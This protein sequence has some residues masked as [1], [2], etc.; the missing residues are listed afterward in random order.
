MAINPN[1]PRNIRKKRRFY[2][3]KGFWLTLFLGTLILGAATAG[4]GYVVAERYTRE[5]RQRAATYDLDSINVLEV[6]SI[7]LDRNDK[8]IGRIFVQNRSIIPISE[9]PKILIDALCAGE[10]SRFFTHKGVDYIGILRAAKLN[11]QGSRQGASTITQQLARNAY[12]LKDEAELRKES[13]VQRK[14]VE[15]FLAM[16]IEHHF[17]KQQILEFYLNRIYF[18]SGFHGIRSAALGYFGKEPKDLSVGECASLV[19]LIKN[20]TGRSPINAPEVNR[21]GRNYVLGRMVE[22]KSLTAKEAERCKALPLK[23]N[24]QPLRRGTSHLYERIAEAVAQALGDDAL[25]AGGFKI[26][27]TILKEAQDAAEQSLLESLAR[28]EVQPGYAHPKYAD[29]RKGSSEPPEYLQGAVLMVDHESG[30]VLA[31]VGGRDY[32]QAPYDFIES[33]KRPLGTAFFPFLYAAGLSG[34]QTPATLVED[35]AMDNRAVMVGGREGI[36]GEWGM[37]TAAPPYYGK[38]TARRAFES[39]KI[40]AT[41]RFGSLVGLQRIAQTGVAFGLPMEHAELLQR[42]C[43]GWEEASMKQA[44]SAIAAFGRGGKTG[45][46]KLVY[47]DRVEDAQGIVKYRHEYAAVVSP[48]AVD[49]ATAWQIHSM[50]VGSCVRGSAAG[51]FDAL[52]EK[53][54]PGAGKGGSTYDFSDTWFL[55]YNKRVT[56]GVWTG[57][58][59]AGGGPIYAGAFSRD[60]ALP[61]WQ[62]AMNAAAPAFGGGE[63]A[64]P[65][66]L[67]EVPVCS[68]SG[69]R[70]TQFCQEMAED[71]ATGKL[72][73]RST[74]VIESFRRGTES[75]A[76]CSV[77]SGTSN[78]GLTALV[79]QP[80][81]DV[82]PVVPTEPFVIGDD[83]YHAEVPSSAAVSR[84]AGLIRRRTNVLDSLDV[85]DG[86]EKINLPPPA[87][88]RI[89]ED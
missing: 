59:Q 47:L 36:L 72:R 12:N 40:A 87:R 46:A 16:R 66:N 43:V 80:A 19:T 42:L 27:T 38:I 51:A 31:H 55:G 14:L 18:G 17:N 15:G 20:P 78:D 45:P 64:P 57:F 77:H 35:E 7:I 86:D 68:V 75:Q 9:V 82:A 53:P 8:E 73:S 24:P 2:K 37:E 28:A 48:Q 30:E 63:I 54:F 26:H 3:R 70:S 5:Y 44:V 58:L 61:V 67:V 39:S 79:S 89:E 41:V 11:L 62:A 69:Q 25:A 6:P 29:Y 74:S 81:L 1:R 56:C 88:L 60:L 83:P 33:G 50:M 4:I 52:L 10:D 76:F 21:E 84:D 34:T 65:V 85:G 49:A 23:L 22:E 13:T 71:K 32:A